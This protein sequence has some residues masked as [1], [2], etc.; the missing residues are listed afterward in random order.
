M[1][2][3]ECDA[4]RTMNPHFLSQDKC[5]P[6]S[7]GSTMVTKLQQVVSQEMWQNMIATQLQYIAPDIVQN[8]IG[9]I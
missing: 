2:V 8:L 9:L 6:N 1:I 3:L 7:M 4:N 5:S